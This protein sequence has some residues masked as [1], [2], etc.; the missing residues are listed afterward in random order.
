M[1]IPESEAAHFLLATGAV[2]TFKLGRTVP[3]VGF[4]I[5]HFRAFLRVAWAVQTNSGVLVSATICIGTLHER[6]NARR[7][8]Q[9]AGAEEEAETAE[10]WQVC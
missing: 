2:L 3:V 6:H 9:L 7:D 4:R 10:H 5:R 8:N 1:H